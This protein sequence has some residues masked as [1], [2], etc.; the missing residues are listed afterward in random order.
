ML[1]S[2]LIAEDRTCRSEDLGPRKP[3]ERIRTGNGRSRIV[4]PVAGRT[5]RRRAVC[6]SSQ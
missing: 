2:V 6:L 1:A 3:P 5:P 4:V